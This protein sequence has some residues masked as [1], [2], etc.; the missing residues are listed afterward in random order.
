ML[1]QVWE[2]VTATELP[3]DRWIG[4]IRV[5]FPVEGVLE[6]CLG[7]QRKNAITGAENHCAFVQAWNC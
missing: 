4:K 1:K 5:R 6:D 3:P 2:D 7:F